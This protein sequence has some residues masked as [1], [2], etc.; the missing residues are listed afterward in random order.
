MGWAGPLQPGD[1]SWAYERQLCIALTATYAILCLASG[2]QT[3]RIV[4]Y[5]HNLRSFQFAFHLLCFIWTA[6]R[7]LFFASTTRWSTRYTL[8]VYWVP[9]DIQ[10]ATFSLMVV[11]YAYLL[12]KRVWEHKKWIVYTCFVGANLSMFTLTLGY[13]FLSYR[14]VSHIELAH[15][16]FMAFQFLFLTLSYARYGRQLYYASGRT[17]ARWTQIPFLST[18]FVYITLFTLGIFFTRFVYNVITAFGIGTIAIG[19]VDG[20]VRIS[21]QY[22]SLTVFVA[23]VSKCSIISI[24]RGVGN[25]PYPHGTHLIQ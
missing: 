12:H 22:C 2:I 25:S 9:T 8:F 19:D 17:L 18:R 10:F 15:H 1:H 11:F 14:G 7:V 3:F 23:Q 16:V 13:I 4:I 24:V 6:L 5:R 20:G 21:F